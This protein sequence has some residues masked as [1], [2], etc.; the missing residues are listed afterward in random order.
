MTPDGAGRKYSRRKR[1]GCSATPAQAQR[2]STPAARQVAHR[3]HAGVVFCGKRL[4]ECCKRRN[5]R[6][7]GAIPGLCMALHKK[8]GRGG[9]L[10]EEKRKF[11]LWIYPQTMAK[12]EQMYRQADC[13]SRSEFIEKAINFYS[14]CLSTQAHQDYLSHALTGTLK[15]IVAEGTNR[16]SRLL[17]KLGVE[18][19]MLQ[20]VVAA[21][22]QIDPS[23]LTKLRGECVEELKRIN[24]CF[25]LEDAVQWQQEE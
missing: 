7:P 10:F 18:V 9:V 5:A 25:Q 15:A 22:Q 19:A 4:F 14:G 12:V 20:N 6:S 8:L 1:R 2:R 21:G 13:Q 23:R 24:G 11:A 3:V 17:F 16:L